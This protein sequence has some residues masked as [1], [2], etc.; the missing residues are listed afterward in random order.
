MTGILALV[1]EA[2]DELNLD[3]PLTLFG[4]H[5]EGDS[6]PRRLRR[7]LTKCVKQLAADWDWQVLTR[8]RTFTSLASETQT[9][10]IPSDFLRF[11]PETMWD[12]TIKLAMTGPLTASE[13]QANK[14]WVAGAV[15]PN[16]R[17]RGNDILT[18][19]VPPAGRS[20]A[21]EYITM[22]VGKNAGG[23]GILAFTADTDT[24]WWDDEL[25]ISGIVLQ[26]R[27]MERQDYAI[28][29]AAFE[30]LKADRIKQDGGRR[31]I[32]MRGS[33]PRSAD[34][35]LAAM[36]SNAVVINSGS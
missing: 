33:N 10:M 25:I 32:N 34:E 18:Y 28:E 30:K 20:F 27:M 29:F 1:T 17:Q 14:A 21:F 13:W 36:R 4:V 2:A 9:A 3:V 15:V 31:K 11:V 22:N 26:H 8:E 35:R 16:F 23:S 24:T 7:A 6:S 12:R 19:P 5:D